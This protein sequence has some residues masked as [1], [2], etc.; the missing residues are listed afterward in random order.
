M[1]YKS[2]IGNTYYVIKLPMIKMLGGG[3][4]TVLELKGQI[5]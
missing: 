1:T 2:V 4:S 5:I 3:A